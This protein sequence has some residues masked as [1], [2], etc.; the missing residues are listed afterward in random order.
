MATPTLTK[1]QISG[2]LGPILIDVR[3]GGRDSPRPAVILVHGFKGFKDWGVFPVLAERLAR[4]GFVAVSINVSGSG[5]DDAG[6]SAWPE[7]FGHNRFTAEVTD[8]HQVIEALAAGRLGVVGP[9]VIGLLGHSRG[10]GT[11]ILEAADNPLIRSLVSWAPIA[12]L[13]RWPGQVEE[14]RENGQVIVENS[15]TGQKIP[16]FSDVLDDVEQNRNGSLDIRAAAGRIEIPWLIIHGTADTAVPIEE[17]E[18]LCAASGR[19]ST[20]LLRI[21]GG[22]HTFG[23][24]HPWQGETPELK[25]VLDRTVG[26]LGKSL[27]GR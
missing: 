27:T 22:G 4:A 14:W 18:A 1:H 7:R 24:V 17:G 5:F 15:R 20:E 25:I 19:P 12:H 10:G 13:D 26:W 23:G 2:S 11:T 21:E 8:I 16:I 3:A 9:S 6:N